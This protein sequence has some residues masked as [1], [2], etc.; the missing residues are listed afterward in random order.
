MIS[1]FMS[2]QTSFVFILSFTLVTLPG[3][4]GGMDA[5][6]MLPKISPLCKYC[7]AEGTSNRRARCLMDFNDVSVEAVIPSKAL[8]TNSTLHTPHFCCLLKSNE[9]TIKFFCKISSKHEVNVA[10]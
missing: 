8:S 3:L 9:F 1:F 6:I 4:G 5:F 2:W 7:L 10:N